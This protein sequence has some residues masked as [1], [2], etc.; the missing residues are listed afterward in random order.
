VH[1]LVGAV[2]PVGLAVMLA[3]VRERLLHRAEVL[4]LGVKLIVDDRFLDSLSQVDA[5][6]G[7]GA[8]GALLVTVQ[9]DVAAFQ[10]DLRVGVRLL[11]D[12]LGQVQQEAVAGDVIEPEHH[13]QIVAAPAVAPERP[14]AQRRFG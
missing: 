12:Q 5:V 2:E 3:N 9:R 7:A 10:K 8:V 13:E 1:P 4:V 11:A 6:E 14:V